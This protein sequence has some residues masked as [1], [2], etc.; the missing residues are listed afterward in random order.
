M[1]CTRLPFTALFLALPMR[2]AQSTLRGRLLCRMLSPLLLVLLAGCEGPD[3]EYGAR[4]L[5]PEENPTRVVRY[6]PARRGRDDSQPFLVSVD[7]E[8]ALVLLEGDSNLLVYNHWR[9]DD[10]DFFGILY[11]D[12]SAGLWRLEFDRA[13]PLLLFELERGE[14]DSAEFDTHRSV[15][16]RNPPTVASRW[17]ADKI[18]GISADCSR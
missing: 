15:E 7:C 17:A 6:D 13:Q 3:I 12:G 16:P 18:F 9:G 4:E 11:D 1:R 10:A 2:Q 8:P 14:F 5:S